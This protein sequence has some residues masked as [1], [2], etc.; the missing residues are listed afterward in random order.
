MLEYG[1][2][3]GKVAFANEEYAVGGVEG[4]G[5]GLL[6]CAEPMLLTLGWLARCCLLLLAMWL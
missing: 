6:S 1:S 3:K 4:D 5:G 2:G